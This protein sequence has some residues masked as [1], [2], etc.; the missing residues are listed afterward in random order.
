MT[1]YGKKSQADSERKRQKPF[2]FDIALP[3]LCALDFV[4]FSAIC[5]RAPISSSF[6]LI[7]VLYI[8]RLVEFTLGVIIDIA[9]CMYVCKCVCACVAEF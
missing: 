7:F 4:V 6:A 1:K 5:R 3:S 9:I 2:R 8:F